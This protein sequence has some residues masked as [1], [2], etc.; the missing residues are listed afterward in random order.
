MTSLILYRGYYEL[1][2]NGRKTV[3]TYWGSTYFLVFRLLK[4]Y[5]NISIELAESMLTDGTVYTSVYTQ[6]RKAV[7]DYDK[8]IGKGLVFV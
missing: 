1:R 6:V 5:G 4:R 2:E 3:T 8:G 7:S